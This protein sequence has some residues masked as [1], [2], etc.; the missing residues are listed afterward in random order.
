MS[1]S[2]VQV[3]NTSCK[4]PKTV[5]I[6]LCS[7]DVTRVATLSYIKTSILSAPDWLVVDH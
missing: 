7:N 1:A 5:K 2:A 4:I 6:L 3:L